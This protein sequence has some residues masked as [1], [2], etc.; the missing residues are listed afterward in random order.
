[1]KKTLLLCLLLFALLCSGCS[2]KSDTV[3]KDLYAMDTLMFFQVY[4]DD[5][6]VCDGCVA[7]I[8]DLEA[9]LSVTA[10]DSAVYAINENGSGPL[11]DTAAALLQRTHR[12]TD[13]CTIS[14]YRK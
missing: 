7:I 1:M 4:S 10:P 3:R 6:S 8:Q 12:H 9:E 11:S 2:P 14:C 5:S 13:N